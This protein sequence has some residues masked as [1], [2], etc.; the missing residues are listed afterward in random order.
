MMLALDS[1]CTS[2]C[3]ELPR[4]IGRLAKYCVRYML[5][6]K[7][8]LTHKITPDNSRGGGIMLAREGARGGGFEE[9]RKKKIKQLSDV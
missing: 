3:H 7:L 1:G 6:R 2:G 9:E 4:V 5:A 8:Q